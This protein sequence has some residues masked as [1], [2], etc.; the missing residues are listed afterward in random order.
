[1][2][3]LR[4]LAGE[5]S[6]YIPGRE[7][8]NDVDLRRQLE[9]YAASLIKVAQPSVAAL[10]SVGRKAPADWPACSSVTSDRYG[11]RAY[12]SETLATQVLIGN[13][14]GRSL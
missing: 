5:P 14:G 10:L 6:F 12:Y 4:R 3:C 1:M 8:I 13:V 11:M 2:K 7:R 9:R